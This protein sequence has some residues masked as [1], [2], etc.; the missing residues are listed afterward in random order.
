MNTIYQS[1]WAKL[2]RIFPDLQSNNSHRKLTSLS[3]M[4]LNLDILSKSEDYLIIALSHYY[5]QNGDLV[6]DPDMEIRV[7]FANRIVEA[8]TYQDSFGYQEV[9]PE[10]SKVNPD[11]RKDLNRFL[12]KWLTN[13][14][15]QGYQ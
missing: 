10:P 3:M 2:N 9:Y 11:I 12:N 1:N 6:P 14:L 5:E 4:D 15:D 13:I 7:D 8:L